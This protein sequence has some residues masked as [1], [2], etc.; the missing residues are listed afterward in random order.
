[1]KKLFLL[2][3]LIALPLHAQEAT[4]EPFPPEGWVTTEHGQLSLI[5]RTGLAGLLRNTIAPVYDLLAVNTGRQPR[6]HLL[7]LDDGVL[8]GCTRPEAGEGVTLVEETPE[9]CAVS[10]DDL[11]GYA[12]LEPAPGETLERALAWALLERFYPLAEFP[13][14]FASGLADFY[15]PSPKA[16]RLLQLRN[17]ARSNRLFSLAALEQS[18]PDP[19]WQAQSYGMILYILD[20]VGVGELFALAGDV[21]DFPAAYQRHVGEAYTALLPN[22]QN[23]IFTRAAETAHGITPYQAPTLMPTATPPPTETLTATPAPTITPT[24]LTTS[25]RQRAPTVTPSHTPT[26]Y[27]A[28]VTPRP[29]GSPLL[30]PTEVPAAP[31]TVGLSQFNPVILLIALLLILILVYVVLSYRR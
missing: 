9:P 6:I 5:A 20:R 29:P 23:W 25:T 26:P 21:Q 14:W 8:P 27:P 19:L 16:E 31:L 28:T 11:G 1:M 3:F 15:A 2:L 10:A 24:V 4:D 22:W 12:L 7:V 18:N 13:A 17:A 30:V